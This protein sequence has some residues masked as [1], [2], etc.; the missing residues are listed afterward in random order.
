MLVRRLRNKRKT[1]FSEHWMHKYP[2]LIENYTPD[3][4]NRLWVSDITYVDLDGGSSYLSLIT[5]AYSHKV[6]GWNLGQTLRSSDTLAALKMALKNLKGNHPQLT[7]TSYVVQV[8]FRLYLRVHS[9]ANFLGNIY[10]SA[11][12]Q[13]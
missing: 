1:T 12:H 3:A 2:N 11:L 10:P 8:W 5:D 6:V 7:R 13:L 9:M 4:P